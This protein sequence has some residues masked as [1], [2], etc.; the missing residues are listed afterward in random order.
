[1]SGTERA[2]LMTVA[3]FLLAFA[4]WGGSTPEQRTALRKAI[5]AAEAE[6]KT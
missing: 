3:K 6:R 5:D 4:A 2:L 1:M